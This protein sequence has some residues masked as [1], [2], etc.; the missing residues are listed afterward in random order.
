[1]CRTFLFATLV[2]AVSVAGPSARAATP[3]A[4]PSHLQAQPGQG[5][6][7]TETTSGLKIEDLKVG[8]KAVA[9]K[10]KRV[11]VHYTG[12]LTNGKK[13]DSS[14]DSNEPFVFKLGAGEVIK[15][16]D[17][18]VEGMKVGG[19]R[20][21]IIPAHLAY[22]DRGVGGVIPPNSELNFEIELLA[23]E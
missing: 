9:V 5:G 1:M 23:V 19:K 21:L 12:T 22:G 18:G 14:R 7:M 8:D 13:F 10:G 3:P 2:A 16:W 17:E 6:K 15:G 11:T 20:R 4:A